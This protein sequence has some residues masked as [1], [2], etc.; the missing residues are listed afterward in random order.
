MKEREGVCVGENEIVGHKIF[1]PKLNIL[2]RHLI[3][4]VCNKNL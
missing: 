4:F 3:F 2:E 1:F